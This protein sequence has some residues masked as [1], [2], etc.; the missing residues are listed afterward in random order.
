M[1][2]IY[3][4]FLHSGRGTYLVK[5]TACIIIIVDLSFMKLKNSGLNKEVSDENVLRRTEPY[6]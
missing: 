5:S 3:S 4:N 2:L 1:T 6:H